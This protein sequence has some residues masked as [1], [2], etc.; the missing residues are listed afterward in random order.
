MWSVV[1][2]HLP[3]AVL[4]L[5]LLGLTVGIHAAY[6]K[7]RGTGLS[8]LPVGGGRLEAAEDKE[9]SDGH[10]AGK[11]VAYRRVTPPAPYN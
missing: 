8:R 1:N 10:V 4:V 2:R 3:K 9:D 6:S 5:V 11:S 7:Y